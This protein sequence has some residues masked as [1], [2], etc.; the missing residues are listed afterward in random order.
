MSGMTIDF[1]IDLGTTNSS[2]AQLKGT[3]VEVVKN[4]DNQ[5]IT[6]SAVH[7][8]KKGE[9]HVGL[10]AK[11][12]LEDPRAAD[13]VYIEFKRRMGTQHTYEF[14][15]SGLRRKPEELSADIL[16]VLRGDAQQ[17]TGEQCD[18]AVITV[19]AAFEQRQCEATRR[20]AEIAGLIQS[21]L[22]QEPVAAALAYGFQDTTSSG[23][24]L[25]YDFGGGTFDVA[26][27]KAEDGT[28]SVVNHG[29][30]NH[31]GGSEIDWAIIEHVVL[32]ALHREYALADL[33]RGEQRWRSTLAKLKRLVELAKI[34]LSR[35]EKV[36]LDIDGFEDSNGEEV[37][38]P[39]ELTREQ[40]FHAAEPSILRS[41]DFCRKVLGEKDLPATS[42]EKMILVGGP[43]LAPYFRE[44][45]ESELGIPLEFSVDP[46]TVVARGAAVFAGTQLRNAASRPRARA[47]QCNVDLKYNPIGPDSDPRV[48]GIVSNDEQSKLYGY[49]IEF[50]NRQSQWRSGKV[51]LKENGRFK[52]N[53]LAEEGL[54]NIFD[55]ELTDPQGNRTDIVPDSLTY[56]IG[57]VISDQIVINTISVAMANNQPDVFF[58]KGE[59]LPI[60]AS[61]VYRSTHAV[62]TGSTDDALNVPVVEGNA[63]LA[64]RNW[65]LGTLAIRGRDIK[66]DLPSGSEI[67]VTLVLDES[68]ILTVKAY[69]PLLDEEF[70]IVTSRD[71]TDA[72][73]GTLARDLEQERAR[74]D[75]IRGSST[76]EV[77]RS[78]DE[79]V[80]EI[81]QI[82]KH[83][84]DDPDAANKANGRILEL[85]IKLDEVEEQVEWPNTVASARDQ[86][87]EVDRLVQQAGSHEQREQV[88]Q[89]RQE[90][91][92]LIEEQRAEALK[93]KL[94]QLSAL[95]RDVL[96]DKPEFWVSM[97]HGLEQD[98][99]LMSDAATAARLIV[100]GQ[101]YMTQNNI[102]GL[103]AVVMQLLQLLPREEAERIQRGYQSGL[104]R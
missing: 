65:L 27:M 20:A 86:M 41:I 70:E 81:R 9:A 94:D 55:I 19:P 89:L 35:M 88:R 30:D 15:S 22:L 58:K 14:A 79:A 84:Q 54:Q 99:H 53:L 75:R 25:V 39:I 62:K 96:V 80:R 18:A 4:N 83:A 59:P 10:R 50:V 85:K 6:P 57:S 68:R 5:D 74:L 49:N 91:E 48:T 2:I 33:K 92:V 56:T 78:A 43:T 12:R 90:A 98:R 76:E 16:K 24:W 8:N 102:Q 28:I 73:P 47:G 97:F 77:E 36:T 60:Q 45:L 66:R 7:I 13:D 82:L 44:T 67:E 71:D 104:M 1:G 38:L 34:D 32:P 37:E 61:R 69:L 63:D 21:P 103:R 100:Q 101:Q 46:M 42:V 40:L 26:L 72:D 23:Y 11:G 51:P 93:R 3:V 29:G 64:D 95:A 52:V 31:L 17:M 87:D